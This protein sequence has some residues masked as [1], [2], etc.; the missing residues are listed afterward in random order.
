V[1]LLNRFE[2][3]GQTAETKLIGEVSGT[4]YPPVRLPFP[5]GSCVFEV[6]SGSFVS[7][8]LQAKIEFGVDFAVRAL[9]LIRIRDIFIDL[10]VLG[11]NAA[12]TLHT[13]SS[14]ET[15]STCSM[16]CLSDVRMHVRRKK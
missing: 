7:V 16:R 3:V 1:P 6:R 2:P 11:R 4:F 9:D 5:A 8:A 13:V 12:L 14:S 15:H 10:I